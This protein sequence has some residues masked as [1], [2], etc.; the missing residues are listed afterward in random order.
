MVVKWNQPLTSNYSFEHNAFDYGILG[1]AVL[2]SKIPTMCT[3]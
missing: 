2:A 3:C 1:A